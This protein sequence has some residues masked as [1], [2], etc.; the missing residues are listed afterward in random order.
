M[1]DYCV[2]LLEA[3]GRIHVMQSKKRPDLETVHELIGCDIVESVDLCGFDGD[4]IM[5]VDQEGW[6]KPDPVLNIKASLLYRVTPFD[7]AGNALIL[8]RNRYDWK[9]LTL[10]ETE[11]L[12]KEIDAA[13][14]LF[15][16]SL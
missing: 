10:N 6:L 7:I 5:L 1:K 4:Y 14:E 9:A 15:C 8:K 13:F 12:L 3:P 11:Y 16:K 2:I